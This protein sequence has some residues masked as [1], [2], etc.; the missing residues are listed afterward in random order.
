VSPAKSFKLSEIAILIDAKLEGNPDKQIFGI[1]SL[2]LASDKEISFITKESYKDQLGKTNASAVICSSSLSKKFEG[3]KLISEDPYLSY[4][5]C[6]AL[7]KSRL[8]QE[9][10][11]SKLAFVD[12]PQSLGCD[13]RQQARVSAVPT[14]IAD[15]GR[16]NQFGA[17]ITYIF[18]QTTPT[19]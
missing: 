18:P 8:V 4:A 3:C 1:S 15:I 13:L 19:G 9:I 17:W 14:C 6:T 10:G 16:R 7:F 2:E 11:V 12:E 5:K